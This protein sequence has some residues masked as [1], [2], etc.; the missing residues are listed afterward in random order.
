M[1]VVPLVLPELG[2]FSFR[3][4]ED[5]EAPTP[6]SEVASGDDKVNPNP[7]PDASVAVPT[8]ADARG[9]VA[10]GSCR[11]LVGLTTAKADEC[12]LLAPGVR[13]ML[14]LSKLLVR[15]VRD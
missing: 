9:R 7:S 2:S 4:L 6:F 15:S 10:L 11:S 3:G 1:V 5:L 13:R 12:I 14:S 8:A